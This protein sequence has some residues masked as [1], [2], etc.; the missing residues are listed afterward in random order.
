MTT[1]KKM[2]QAAAGNAGGA[3]L[4]ITEVF[5]TYLYEGTSGSL[6]VNN[7][8]DLDGEGGMV[9]HK[10][11]DIAEYHNLFDTERG[12][13]YILRT[14]VT[15][16]S[17][18]PFFGQAFTSTGFSLNT[19]DNQI[20][21]TA[22]TYVSWT[23]RKAPK[24]FDIVGPFTG[25]GIAGRTVAHNLGSVPGMIIVKRTDGAQSWVVY[26]RGL[27]NGSSPEDYGIIL[28]TTA[29]QTDQSL[30]WNDT[31]PTSTNF[32]LGSAGSVNGSGSTY[33]AYVFAHNNNDGG[34]G[35]DA[36]QDVIK[37]GNYTGNGTDKTTIDLGFEAQWVLLK[38]SDGATDWWIFDNMRG[39]PVRS[40]SQYLEANTANAEAASGQVFG[41]NQGFMVDSGDYNTNGEKYIYMAT[42]RG[43]LA[44]PEAATEVYHVEKAPGGTEYS[45]GFPLDM[46][47][48]GVYD[49]QDNDNF[50][51]I[52]R[53]RGSAN[54]LETS[55]ADAEKTY[56][57]TTNVK[58]DLQN[59]TQTGTWPGNFN[60]IYYN[61]R[62]APSFMDC[63]AYSGNS[64]TNRTIPHSLGVTP[65]MVWIKKRNGSQKWC[66][67]ST[68]YA[69]G[70]HQVLNETGA[71]EGVGA[72]GRIYYAGW[73]SSTFGVG[74]DSDTNA[75][76]G[77]T[78]IAYLFATLDGVS[79]VSSYTGNGTSQTINA[80]F[81][82][83]ARFIMIKRTDSAGDWYVWDTARG[84][85]TGNSPHISL[86]ST[87]AGVSDDSIDPDSSGFI[88]NQIAA[89]NINVSSAAYIYYAVA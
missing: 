7:G 71:V 39:L 1:K 54:I 57:L 88:V 2:L 5:S 37:C 10:G 79:K 70:G 18:G 41:D 8:I 13:G 24:F 31:A 69:G 40:S 29:G 32:T 44:P 45:N 67:G 20:N 62:R 46:I 16:A 26:H 64:A 36:D 58:F 85:V 25:D 38:R 4:D 47:I 51:V 81:T 42:R 63:V 74:D 55:A 49:N 77:D 89:T 80:G 19:A 28:N 86:N 48:F 84:V 87:S 6:S 34:F 56:G 11:R 65:E 53:L 61:F 43:P 21:S 60:N 12:D 78:F 83:G 50:N 3:G 30:Y 66:V 17:D 76:T 9:W 15:N 14:N 35:P 33:I 27:N 52:D 82:A 23:F 22:N 75:G 68:V 59:S 72:T 73:N